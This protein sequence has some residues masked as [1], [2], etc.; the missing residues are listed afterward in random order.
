MIRRV[1]A[2]PTEGELTSASKDYP[3]RVPCSFRKQQGHVVLDQIRTIDKDRL[4]KRL[5]TID[6]EVQMEVVSVLQRM[7]AF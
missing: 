1:L 6:P 5:G 4:L 7:F 2:R 3:A